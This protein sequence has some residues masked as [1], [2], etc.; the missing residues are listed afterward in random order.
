MKTYYLVSEEALKSM[1]KDA[2]KF[3]ALET[4]GVDN[5]EGIRRFS[6]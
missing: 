1:L 6:L 4:G 2:F 3:H 5:W